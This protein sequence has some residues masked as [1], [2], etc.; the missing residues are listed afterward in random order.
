MLD[1]VAF[2]WPK[3]KGWLKANLDQIGF[4][5]VNYDAE[6]WKALAEQLM[7]DHTVSGWLYFN[8]FL[9]SVGVIL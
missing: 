2:P 7:K 3:D 1:E 9:D 4:Y 8:S 6:N 5:R